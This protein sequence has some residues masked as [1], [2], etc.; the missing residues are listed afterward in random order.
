VAQSVL[1]LGKR[2]SRRKDVISTSTAPEGVITARM[3]NLR[4]DAVTSR[5][6][7]STILCR[8]GGKLAAVLLSGGTAGQTILSS[9]RP[10]HVSSAFRLGAQGQLCGYRNP[11]EGNSPEK[12]FLGKILRNNTGEHQKK[13]PRTWTG[14]IT[15]RQKKPSVSGI[16][17]KVIEKR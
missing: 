9:S 2:R 12:E 16:V 5:C 3:A 15:C 11:G 13:S 10:D 6:P 4:H 17:D 8:T 7:V 1:F 14:I